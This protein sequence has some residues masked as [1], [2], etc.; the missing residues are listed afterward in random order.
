MLLYL[1]VISCIMGTGREAYFTN[2]ER[3]RSGGGGGTEEGGKKQAVTTFQI[4]CIY[5]ATR[6]Y[7][8]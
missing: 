4:A 6:Y 5:F 7:S 1:C 8:K 2:E 3:D